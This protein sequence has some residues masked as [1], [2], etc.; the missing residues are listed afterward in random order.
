[1]AKVTERQTERLM[2]QRRQGGPRVDGFFLDGE[3]MIG[4]DPSQ[5]LETSQAWQRLQGM[6]RLAEVKKTVEGLIDTIKYNYRREIDGQPMVGYSLNLS[7][8]SWNW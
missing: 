2:Q 8:K 1:M 5:S 3:D 6:I 7:R 4:P